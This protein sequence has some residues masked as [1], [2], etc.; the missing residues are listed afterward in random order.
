MPNISDWPNDAVV[1]SLSQVLETGQIPA[2]ILFEPEGV[3]RDS[4]PSRETREAVTPTTTGGSRRSGEVP[5]ISMR[6]SGNGFWVEDKIAGTLDAQ[7][8]C[9]GHASRPAVIAEPYT[10]AIRGRGDSHNLEHRQDGLA[11]A[12]LTPNGGRGG[13]GVGAVACVTGEQTNALTAEGHD[14][15]EDGTGRGNPII[16]FHPTQDP[17]HSDDGTT[18][19][20]GCGSKGGAASVAIMI[21]QE[22]NAHADIAGTLQRKGEGGFEGSVASGMQVR[23]LTPTECERLQGFPDGY[24]ADIPHAP[25]AASGQAKA[26][27]LMEAGDPKYTEIDGVIWKVSHAD[28]PRYKALGN[29][30][31]VPCAAWI[32]RRIQETNINTST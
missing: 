12:I 7:M 5:S 22:L 6:E 1:C 26:R 19:A 31:A 28:G 30:W 18:H 20:M 17:V 23:R 32:G 8:G 11:N 15:S 3:R 16:A 24:T 13:I 14:A 29:S 25:V 9:S 10:L 2:E 4:A 27:R 21:D